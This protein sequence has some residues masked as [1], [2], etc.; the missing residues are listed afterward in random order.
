MLK[1]ILQTENDYVTTLMRVVLGLVMLPHGL[2]KT[3]GLFGG[4]GFSGTMGFFGQMGIPAIFAFLAIMAEFAGSLGL[5]SGLLTRVAAFGIACVMT[6]AVLTVHLSNGFFMNWSGSQGGEGFEYHL[7]ALAL[8]VAL[9]I[10]GGG[11]ASID[12]RLA[13]IVES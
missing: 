11:A 2:Q 1:R 5:I 10:R 13:A 12:R 7:L 3:F 4:A 9:I 6:V 8:A